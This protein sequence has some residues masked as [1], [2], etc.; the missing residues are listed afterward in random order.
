MIRTTIF[1]IMATIFIMS[2]FFAN[3]GAIGYGLYLWG[4]VGLT[5]ATSAWTAFVLWLKLMGIAF[6]SFIGTYMTKE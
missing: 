3:I 6:V 2:A 4:S 5:F 1:F